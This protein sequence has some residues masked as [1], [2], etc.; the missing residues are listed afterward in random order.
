MAHRD[1]ALAAG[2]VCRGNTT[3]NTLFRA[4][5]MIFKVSEAARRT[6][7]MGARFKRQRHSP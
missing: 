7:R 4:R 1:T 6:S 5:L 2:R 3:R